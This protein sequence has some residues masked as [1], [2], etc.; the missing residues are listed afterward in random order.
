MG[1]LGR[2]RKSCRDL[3]GSVGI[4]GK[5]CKQNAVV[6]RRAVVISGA[7]VRKRAVVISG[8]RA[9]GIVGERLHMKSKEN[10]WT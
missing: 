1:E 3:C 7:V 6:R 5:L 8:E 10:V 4:C 9:A 2:T